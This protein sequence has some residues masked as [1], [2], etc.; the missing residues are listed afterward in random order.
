MGAP[1]LEDIQMIA[2]DRA[3][4][5]LNNDCRTIS[6]TTGDCPACAGTKLW[7]LTRWLERDEVEVQNGDR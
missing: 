5:C 1:S 7:P 4:V 3:M 2:M 6:N